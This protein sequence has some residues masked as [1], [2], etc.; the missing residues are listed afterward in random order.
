MRFELPKLLRQAPFRRYWIGQS[1]SLLGDEVG[2][3]ALPLTAVLLLGANSQA[4][5]LLTAVARIPSLLFSIHAGVWVD[6]FGR[7]RQVMLTAD[8]AR[9]LLFA[10]LPVAFFLGR[11]NLVGLL[12]IEFLVC[13]FSVLFQVSA[14]TVFVSLVSKEEYVEANSLLTGSRAAAFLVGPGIGGFLV[15]AFSAPVAMLADA[16]S[17]AASAVSLASI[18]PA[19]PARAPAQRG[20][21]TAGLRFVWASPVLRTSLATNTTLKFF[22]AIFFAL[23]VL[24]TTRTLQVTPAELGIILGPGSVG[25]LLGSGLAGRVAKRIGL[26][27][28]FLIGTIL[29]TVPVLLVPAV[30]GPHLFVVAVLLLA[31]CFSG[32][33]V[34]VMEI[35]NGAIVAAAIPN[36]LR[37]RVEGAM[38]FVSS[39]VGLL[40][41]LLGGALPPVIGIRPTLWIATIGATL[42]CLWLLFSQVMQV[43]TVADVAPEG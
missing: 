35:S 15:T 22:R 6:R 27:R 10:A 42:G 33:G 21:A 26:G 12:T 11:L 18:H 23:Y 7:R 20:G 4:M 16:F 30:G 17:Y 34:M 2:G 41:A 37:A 25:A 43:K 24:Y 39:G 40:G 32:M 13:V 31:E 9:A 5:G 28:T 14:S 1:L 3:L 19:E 8:I 38:R 29:Y 36:E